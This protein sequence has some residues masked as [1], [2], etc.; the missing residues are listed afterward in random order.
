MGTTR[1]GGDDERDFVAAAV[2]DGG[3]GKTT[4]VKVR[5]RA[6]LS[7]YQ[8]DYNSLAPLDWRV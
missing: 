6:T 5:L 1:A 3:T 2:G 7:A 8:A 4:F